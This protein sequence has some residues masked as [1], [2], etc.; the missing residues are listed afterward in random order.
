M[1]Q[2][3]KILLPIAFIACAVAIWA[4]LFAFRPEV[5]RKPVEVRYPMVSVSVV[6]SKDLGIPVFTRGTVTPGTEIQLTSEVGGQVLFISDNFAN[7]GFFRKGEVLVKIDP[8]E[9]EVNI[10]RAEASLAQAKQNKVQADAERQARSQI[11]GGNRT[12]FARFEVQYRQAEASY[13]AA[14]AELEA[15]KMQKTRTVI[16]APFDGRVRAKSVDVG[17]YVRP[18]LQIAVLYAVNTAEVRLPLSDRQL[19]LVDVPLRFGSQDELNT[20]VTL[21]GE[22]GG[23]KYYWDGKIVRAEGGLD[24]RNRL[25][26]VVAQVDNPYETDSSQPSRPPL[27]AGF[28]VEAQIEGRHHNSVFVVPRKALRNG[29]QLWLVD[30]NNKLVK[31]AVEVLYKGRDNIYVNAGL[32]DGEKV[33]LSQLDIAV[34][35]M[36]VRPSI[37][38]SFQ[39][40]ESDSNDLLGGASLAKKQVA[41]SATSSYTKEFSRDELIELA[42]DAKTKYESMSNAKKDEIKDS[43][44]N[45]AQ[46]V[47]KLANSAK[48]T[49][50]EQEASSKTGKKDQLET[51][52]TLVQAENESSNDRSMSPLASI[53]EADV[54]EELSTP[55][56]TATQEQ[57]P[58]TEGAFTETKQLARSAAVSITKV[59]APKPLAESMQ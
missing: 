20:K 39:P 46:I 35:G 10:K 51:E 4:L 16:T 9:Y 21:E 13:E 7:G 37:E 43:V 38:Q 58:Q 36:T 1:K 48:S 54:K 8:L 32:N 6:N 53:I 31:R 11:R 23:K 55:K 47:R 17:Q 15:A 40:E 49:P 34:E 57:P 18:G 45:A 5:K 42:Q 33:V 27:A 22:Y 52:S 41:K 28:F 3:L 19:G 29:S 25:L 12:E 24:E 59:A 2:A 30:E 50:K 26:Y 44:E 56:N 14:R